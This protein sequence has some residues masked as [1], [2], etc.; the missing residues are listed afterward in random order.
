MSSGRSHVT[1][2]N[3]FLWVCP[4]NGCLSVSRLNLYCYF[5]YGTT[6]AQPI[7]FCIF[8]HSLCVRA[9]K[10][11]RNFFKSTFYVYAI[12]TVHLKHP[13][14]EVWPVHNAQQSCM[15]SGRCFFSLFLSNWIVESLNGSEANRLQLY[16]V[17]CWVDCWNTITI[18]D[19][20]E[21]FA[22]I[23]NH[24]IKLIL[25]EFYFLIKN[26]FSFTRFCHSNRSKCV[27]I[28]FKTEIISFELPLPVEVLKRKLCKPTESFF[29]LSF[30]SQREFAPVKMKRISI[31]KKQ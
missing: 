2:Y 23:L 19:R 13:T 16:N 3:L 9:H 15:P 27:R 28:K 24:I 8:P 14:H 11:T 4:W 20:V 30:A 7:H 29:P 6:A 18:N 22:R 10:S 5:M 21:I 26:G 17:G 12:R 31:L 25:M 1:R